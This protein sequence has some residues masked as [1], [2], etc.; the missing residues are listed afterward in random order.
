MPARRGSI[1]L[2][3]LA[4]LAILAGTGAILLS[5]S[6]R[7][8][9]DANARAGIERRALRREDGRT[10][11]D[12]AEPSPAAPSTDA[13]PAGLRTESDADRPPVVE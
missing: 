9:R 8:G 3:F 1:V 2:V 6:S 7:K 11:A 13:R 4:A 10:I 12:P 5:G